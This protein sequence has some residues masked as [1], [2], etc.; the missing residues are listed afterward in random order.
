MN[1]NISANKNSGKV[2]SVSKLN[3]DGA[4]DICYPASDDKNRGRGDFH[5]QQ[6]MLLAESLQKNFDSRSDVYISSDIFVYYE[7]GNPRRRFAPDVMVCFGVEN[8]KRRTYKL[9]EEK[10]APSVIF[11]IASS[12]TWEK[13]VTTKRKLYE[14]LG[15]AEFYVFDPEYKYLP[16]A[17]R[18]YHLEFGELA[19]QSISKNRIFSPALGLE[20]VDTKENLRLFDPK[21]NELLPTAKE[22]KAELDRLKQKLQ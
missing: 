11:E 8:K 16:Q 18:A 20:L 12:E 2:S 6:R 1:P 21:N 22:L 13:D 17:L 19:R 9:W 10:V 5:F 15:V 7:E 4:N 14:D 3:G